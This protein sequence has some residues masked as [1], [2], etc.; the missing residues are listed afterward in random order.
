MTSKN[1][2][3][4]LILEGGGMRGLFTAGVL[5]VFL[6]NGIEFD[7]CVGNSAGA[8]FGCNIKSKQAGRVLRYNK[9]YSRDHRYA[10]LRSLIFTGDYFGA[11]FC[12]RKLPHELDVFDWDTYRKN[13]M[14]FY[15][16]C[17]DVNT[18]KPVYRKL[19]TCDDHDLTWMRASASLPLAS[20]I[21]EIDGYQLLDGGLAD[22]IPIKFFEGLGYDRNIVVLT[23]PRSFVKK[24]AGG[25]GLL[26]MVYR[27]YPE[28]AK[29]MMAR[30]ER[31]NDVT[32]YIFD[33]ADKGEMLVICPDEPLN[34]GR[35][36]KD[37]AELQRCYDAGR[38]ACMTQLEKI[39]NFLKK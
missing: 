28:I 33:K 24:P 37:P 20:K 17:F 10:S 31:Y 32:K 29:A 26:K 9:K 22:S 1:S 5:D 30:H 15:C 12:Y 18:G 8:T 4:G 35:V 16:V 27:K 2:K 19:E 6:E 3:T 38:R 7:G 39:R 25:I 11:D 13:P 21:V 14:E 34:I 23:Q 36:E